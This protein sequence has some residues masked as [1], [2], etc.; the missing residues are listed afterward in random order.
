MDESIKSRIKNQIFKFEATFTSAKTDDSS[1]TLDFENKKYRQD[2]LVGLIRDV[3]PYFALTEDEINSL[4]QSEFNKRSFTRISDANRN[5]KGDYGEL[6]LFIILSFFYDVPKFVTKARLRSTT[7]EQIKGFDCAHFSIESGEV[8]LWLGE[9]KFHQS[10]SS[11]ISSSLSSLN[12][13]LSNHVKIKSELKLLGGE[14]EINKSLD[15]ASYDALKPCLSG[16]RSLDKVKINVPVLLTYN[17]KTII[18]SCDTD[19]ADTECSE[20]KEKLLIELEKN[21]TSVYAKAWP[22]KKN[23]KIIFFILP[24]YSVADLKNKIDS[25]EAAMKF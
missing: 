5:S 10:I 17:S 12:D 7:R 15:E 21:F 3:V 18:E 19:E 8:T 23:I 24:L 1:F 9:A 13:H 6:L 20:F 16:G 11:A 14:I 2:E 22:L 25:V 4:D